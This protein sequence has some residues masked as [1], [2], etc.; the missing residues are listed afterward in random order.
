MKQSA[1]LGEKN[2]PNIVNNR[3]INETGEQCPVS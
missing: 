2:K 1:H 3:A